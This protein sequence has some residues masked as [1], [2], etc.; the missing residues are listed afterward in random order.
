MTGDEWIDILDQLTAIGKLF[1]D[2]DPQAVVPRSALDDLL[3]VVEA[4][5]G[6]ALLAE[7]MKGR[8]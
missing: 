3:E 6:Q 7:Y 4:E 5:A 8:S 1:D 2:T